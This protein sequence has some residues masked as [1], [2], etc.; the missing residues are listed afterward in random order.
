[1]GKDLLFDIG[2]FF[3]YF[4]FLLK[5][6]HNGLWMFSRHCCR[7]SLFTRDLRLY[8]LAFPKNLQRKILNIIDFCNGQFYTVHVYWHFTVYG[9]K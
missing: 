2:F 9:A 7:V 4:F 8:R 1:M 5:T 3:F 6:A